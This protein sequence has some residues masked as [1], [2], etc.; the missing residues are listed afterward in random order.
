MITRS[1]RLAP[2]ISIGDKDEILACPMCVKQKKNLKS[3]RCTSCGLCTIKTHRGCPVL[4]N[5]VESAYDADETIASNRR[6]DVVPAKRDTYLIHGTNDVNHMGNIQ[7]AA[8]SFV[9]ETNGKW[10]GSLKD[11][12][13]YI[14]LKA[15]DFRSRINVKSMFDASLQTVKVCKQEIKLIL[16]KICESYFG[17]SS[18]ELNGSSSDCIFNC[19]FIN[20]NVADYDGFL[21]NQYTTFSLLEKWEKIQHL[22]L[23]RAKGFSLNEIRDSLKDHDD[24]PGKTLWKYA[25]IFME[26][27]E[28]LRDY[29]TFKSRSSTIS[30]DVL[31]EAI[32][33]VLNNVQD[34]AYGTQ[35]IGDITV[36]AWLKRYDSKTIANLYLKKFE[37]TN[38]PH[39]SLSTM[40]VVA[41]LVAPKQITSFQGLDNVMC[42]SKEG[43]DFIIDSLPL[44]ELD[45]TIRILHMNVLKD[46]KSSLKSH[47]DESLNMGHDPCWHHCVPFAFGDCKQSH[48][49][50]CPF[51]HSWKVSLDY[52]KSLTPN[53]ACMKKDLEENLDD[54]EKMVGH[55]IRSY[56]QRK[57]QSQIK[58]NLSNNQALIIVDWAM[59]FLSYQWREKQRDWYGKAGI[60]WHESV[61][62]Y[63]KDGALT[64][65]SLTHY[66]DNATQDASTVYLVVK[67]ILDRIASLLPDVKEVFFQSDNGP[68]YH[69][70]DL[71]L[72]LFSA[73]LSS[74]VKILAWIFS[75]AQDGKNACDRLLASKKGQLKKYVDSNKGNILL[76]SD[77][78]KALIDLR[79]ERSWLHCLANMRACVV[80]DG[81]E[82]PRVDIKAPSKVAIS[83]YSDFQFDYSDDFGIIL[84]EQSGFGKKVKIIVVNESVRGSCNLVISSN[85]TSKLETSVLNILEDPIC[86][87]PTSSS[88]KSVKDRRNHKSNSN[89]IKK[90]YPCNAEG[91][92]K[93]HSRARDAD[94]C[95]HEIVQPSLTSRVGSFLNQKL[96]DT[97]TI[98]LTSK[99]TRMRK[100]TALSITAFKDIR[101][102]IKSNYAAKPKVERKTKSDALVQVLTE[103][104]DSGINAH[105]STDKTKK[106]KPE[107]AKR[108]LD[109]MVQN[110]VRLNDGIFTVEDRISVYK[111]KQFWGT[112]SQKRKSMI[113]TSAILNTLYDTSDENPDSFD[114][115]D[116]IVCIV[117][118][119]LNF[120]DSLIQCIDCS[121]Y[122]HKKCK[123]NATSRCGICENPE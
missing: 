53:D 48:I 58:E 106:M 40:M 90:L 39:L 72:P 7:D 46:V 32:D 60:S 54:V 12:G 80:F 51:C 10:S 76:A 74:D 116:E 86:N 62:Y 17:C 45:E 69:T 85:D 64:A 52:L 94:N 47:L 109:N 92:R 104:F 122:F 63:R 57:K 36:P 101:A 22:A 8:K 103:F 84:Q 3:H 26:D 13:V 73:S 96:H 59:K 107:E 78:S 25:K 61:L 95:R 93:L 77:I 38:D 79:D 120:Q 30:D 89:E 117:C 98:S 21:I 28:V 43:I 121:S 111:I 29:F 81:K 82:V 97:S 70:W 67:D 113:P 123:G 119:T 31:S 110:S 68:C 88:A 37:N 118:G 55:I 11:L 5:H 108:L 91:C 35:K 1:S 44:L 105:G 56:V 4:G 27:R 50:N 20:G 14:G 9:D 15:D 112:L 16:D 33:F 42:D 49:Y 71:L 100:E 23:L 2:F 114:K 102:P 34:V 65:M 6:D 83:K 18:E 24:L 99:M 87:E 19:D 66:S 115:E 75:E 41:N